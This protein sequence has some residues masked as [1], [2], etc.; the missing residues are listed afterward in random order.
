MKLA[1]QQLEQHLTKKLAAIYLITGDE[2]LLLHEARDAIRT[3]AH[4][5]GFTERTRIAVESGNDWGKALYSHAHSLSLF[6]TKRILE[7]DLTTNA[8]FS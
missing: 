2:L 6:A 3:A 1:Y 8:H 7:L 5:A 4:L